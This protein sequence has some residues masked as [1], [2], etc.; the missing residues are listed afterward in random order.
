M[1]REMERDEGWE[2]KSTARARESNERLAVSMILSMTMV[3][4][5]S[6]FSLTSST[7]S[8]SLRE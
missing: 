6:S 4:L 5:N 7:L 1:R 2:T 8:S 3:D